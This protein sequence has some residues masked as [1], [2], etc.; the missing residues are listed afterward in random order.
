[1]DYWHNINPIIGSGE[2]ATWYYLT[3]Q[4]LITGVSN[5]FSPF[6][7]LVDPLVYPKLMDIS[8]TWLLQVSI[9]KKYRKICKIS[10]SKN[11]NKQCSPC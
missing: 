4:F 1:V 2:A 3:K 9:K 10:H 5:V 11:N 6:A 7:P 8:N